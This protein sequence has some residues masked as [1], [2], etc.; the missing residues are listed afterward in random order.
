MAVVLWQP[1]NPVHDLLI[2]RESSDE[3][4]RD[5]RPQEALADAIP[6]DDLPE[7]NN[8]EPMNNLNNLDQ[9]MAGQ[10]PAVFIDAS[11]MDEDL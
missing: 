6:M 10:R 1:R 2:N 3:I 5:V 4:S 8:N 11:D 7:D 9:I